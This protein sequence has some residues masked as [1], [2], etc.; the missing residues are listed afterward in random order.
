MS[1]FEDLTITCRDCGKPFILTA[2]DQ[3]FFASMTDEQ[4]NPFKNPV[5]CKPCR[6]LKK[7]Q[8]MGGTYQAPQEPQALPENDF[9]GGGKKKTSGR[10]RNREEEW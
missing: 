7:A 3:A 9:S 8:R 4:G 6:D 5:R 1:E 10:R 2:K